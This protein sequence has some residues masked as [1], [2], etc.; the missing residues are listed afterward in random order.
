MRRT[1]PALL[2]ALAPALARAAGTDLTEIVTP[3]GVTGTVFGFT[4]VMIAIIAYG[5]FRTQKLRHETIRLAI[6]KGQALPGDVLDPV[7]R[8]D[9]RTA[10]LRRGLLL[11]ALGLGIG[12]YLFF[13]SPPG[14]PEHTWAVGFVPGLMGIAY[15]I[16]HAVAQTKARDAQAGGE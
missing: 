3:I 2:L 6:E 14:A 15:L 11:L 8:R 12:L 7:R 10:D 5:R 16:S 13:S 4:A 9:P 1:A